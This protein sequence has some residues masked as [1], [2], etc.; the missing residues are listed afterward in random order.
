MRRIELT[1]NLLII[2]VAILAAVVFTKNLFAGPDQGA[3]R[4]ITKPVAVGTRIPLRDVNWRE[5]GQTMLLALSKDCHFCSESAPFYRRLVREI[6]KNSGAKLIAL[7]PQPVIEGREYL[8]YLGV[9]IEDT[10][11]EQLAPLGVTG[12]PAIVLVN[13]EGVV[14]SSWIGKLSP[15]SE[16]EVL[17]KLQA[18]RAAG[19]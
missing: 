8:E 1:A 18:N 6:E 11:H 5:N 2:T 7:F 12:T 16:T 3:S 17:G 19:S 14:T 15:A 10:R 13:E 9:G 4:G